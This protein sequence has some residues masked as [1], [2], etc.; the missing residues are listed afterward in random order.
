[1]SIIVAIAIDKTKDKTKPYAVTIQVVNPSEI[2]GGTGTTT[3]GQALPVMNITEKGSTITEATYKASRKISRPF[4]YGHIAIVIVNERAARE[5][6]RSSLDVFERDAKEGSRIP[7][8]IARKTSASSI[9][10]V[11]TALEKIPAFSIIGKNK[12]T[13][14]II[15]QTA[16]TKVYEVIENLSLLGREVAIPGI[17]ISGDKKKSQTKKNMEDINLA[18]TEITGFGA[19]YK[20]KLNGWL[21]GEQGLAVSLA[22][23]KMKYANLNIPWTKGFLS[24]SIFNIK[25]DLQTTWENDEPVLHYTVRGSG[26]IDEANGIAKFTTPDEIQRIEKKANVILKK[27]IYSSISAAQKY[28]SDVFGFGE[29]YRNKNNKKWKVRRKNW[30]A[31]FA[32]AK[33]NIDVKLSLARTN[34]RTRSIFHI[35]SKEE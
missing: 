16:E 30:P 6:I 10:S 2:A 19:F 35:N 1:M 27:Q 34:M 24:F 4:F 15:G 22:L 21:E 14:K 17:S 20:G 8:L 11:Q 33:V 32:K 13:G 25:A 5:G 29:I 7:I 12:Y 3:S 26:L 23:K 18:N 31:H 28:K 9:L